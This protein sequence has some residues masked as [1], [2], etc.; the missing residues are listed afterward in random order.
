[1]RRA[2]SRALAGIAAALLALASAA[3]RAPAGELQSAEAA[4]QKASQS[5]R[6]AVATVLTAEPKDS[7]QTG[8]LVAPG[9]VVTIRSGLLQRGAL[10]AEVEV[11]FPGAPA[12]V[13]AKVQADDADTDT[14]I[15]SVPGAKAAP[16]LAMPGEEVQAGL[17]VLLL[18]NTF[19]EGRESTPSVALGILSWM[20]R[21]RA[22]IHRLATSAL[23][24][25]GCAGAPVVDLTGRLVAIASGRI[26][27]S[28]GQTALVPWDAIVGAYARKGGPTARLLDRPPGA[29]PASPGFGDAMTV[30]VAE[31]ARRGKSALVGIRSGEW[32]EIPAGTPADAG[33]AG[34]RPP[35]PP[36]VPGRLAAHDRSSGLVVAKEG[37]ILCPLRVTGWPGP[38]RVLTVDL[39]DGRAFPAKRLGIDERLRVALLKV[40]AAD[41]AVLEPAPAAS[42]ERGRFA[43]GLGFPH[44]AELLES[45][46]ISVGVVSRTGALGRVHPRLRAIQTDAPVSGGNRG[47]PL[48]DIEGRLLGMILDVDDTDEGGYASR[49]RGRYGGNAG[50]GFAISCETIAEVVPLLREGKVLR[51]PVLGVSLEPSGDGLRIAEV[52]EKNAAG[53]ATAAAGAGLR[54]GDLLL[55]IAGRPVP[56]LD[57]LRS[58]LSELFVDDAVEIA[59]LREGARRTAR[60]VL[61]AP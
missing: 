6:P 23:L 4:V 30:A 13:R 60:A 5:A 35:A 25:P 47:G 40:E 58:L 32:R 3:G 16:I 61:K 8:V 45:P 20:Q 38:E 51:T 11:K 10:P 22:G 41:L 59:Y 34:R 42:L 17:P 28:T 18:G 44:E 37:L 36:P 12:A 9:L 50:L 52:V 55:E 57:A 19:G 26:V 46:Q 54:K 31:A 27:A 48:V 56:T 2:R 1:M 14:A 21:D 7:D 43:V 24:N 49:L 53:E 39:L 33:A 15:L 29:K